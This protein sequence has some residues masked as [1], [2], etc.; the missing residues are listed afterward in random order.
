[1]VGQIW[2]GE[3]GTQEAVDAGEEGRVADRGITESLHDMF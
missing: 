3:K 1:M 2:T